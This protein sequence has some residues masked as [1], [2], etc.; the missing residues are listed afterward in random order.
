MRT[1]RAFGQ[2]P[3]IFIQQV[4]ITHIPL[5]WVAGPRAFDTTGDGVNAFALTMA[6]FPTKPLS[7]DRGAFR[8]STNSLSRAI[9]MGFTKSMTARNKRECF[10]IIH[11]HA[12]K[13]FADIL[14]G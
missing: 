10:N 8:F 2:R 5:C 11:R 9:T 12:A 3:V 7:F 6:A 1:C 14:C 13:G 4:Q